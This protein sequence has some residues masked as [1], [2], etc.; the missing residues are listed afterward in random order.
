[1]FPLEFHIFYWLIGT[2]T[3]FFAGYRACPCLEGFYRTNLFA[4]CHKC[5][6]GG[7][8]CKDEYASLKPGFWWQWRNETYQQ[9]YRDFIQ[10]LLASSPALD[11]FSIQYPHPIPTPYKCPF[12]ESCKGGLNSRCENGYEGTICGVCSSGYYKQLQTCMQCPS[13]RWTVGQLVI[14]AAI[15]MIVVAFLVWKSKRRQE[16]HRRR[17]LMDGFFS[18][19]KIVIGFYQVTH[20]VLD[21]FSYIKW[22]GSMEVVSKY[23]GIL[24]L[25]LLQIAPIHCLFSGFRVDALGDLCLIMAINIGVICAFGIAY[26]IRR[27]IILKRQGIDDVEKS[28]E[29]SQTKEV[30]YRNL[31]FFLYVT[32]LSTSSKTASVLPFAC[33]PLCRDENEEICDAYL[34]VDYSVK[35]QGTKY[36]H[37]LTVAYIATAY[38]FALPTASFIAL[39]RKRR[40]MLNAGDIDTPVGKE[41]IAGLHFLFENYQTRSWYWELVEMTRKVILTSGL[42]LVGQESRSYIGLAWVVAGMY[43][44]LF[45]WVKPV[46]DAFE[47]RLMSTSLA[48]TVVN[49]GIGAVSRIPAENIPGSMDLQTDAT[50]MKIL[51]LGANSLMIGLLVGKINVILKFHQALRATF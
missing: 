41:M 46:Q 9:L 21:V 15:L 17:N 48:V 16:K 8:L 14:T 47:N 51:I 35:C 22:P 2:E 13:K 34:K 26:S 39:W 10:N 30:L 40:T 44:M 45:C 27:V 19:L 29:I 49:L 4:E 25:N 32:Y 42:I 6:Q 23:S 7:L 20:G 33:R 5:G 38:I 1:M 18:K 11:K 36:N 37:L 50:A 12:E 28:I 43:G 3:D 24:Q 31:F